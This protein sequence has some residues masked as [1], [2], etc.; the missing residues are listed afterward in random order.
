MLPAESKCCARIFFDSSCRKN[1][2]QCESALG[3]KRRAL[4][5]SS[6]FRQRARVYS[7]IFFCPVVTQ[8]LFLHE[9]TENGRF[10]KFSQ[11]PPSS[12]IL[13]TEI[14]LQPLWLRSPLFQ[15]YHISGTVTFFLAS[16]PP[17]LRGQY[18]RNLSHGAK[19]FFWLISL[20][21]RRET[22]TCAKRPRT[23]SLFP[24]P[25]RAGLLV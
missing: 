20:E 18:F 21:W 11:E 5:N 17:W 9:T 24:C 22:V 23:A 10:A 12:Y 15:K 2:C 3:T 19:F 13:R 25:E 4:F 16:L 7:P 6:F 1:S 14:Q 8:R